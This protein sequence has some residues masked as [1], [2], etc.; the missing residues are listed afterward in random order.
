MT[1]KPDLGFVERK[2]KKNIFSHAI[3]TLSHL[4]GTVDPTS[5]LPGR[6]APLFRYALVEERQ[7]FEH[8]KRKEGYFETFCSG[9]AAPSNKPMWTQPINTLET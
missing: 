9:F 7:L 5:E 8:F 1:I 4:L 2:K 3:S 6:T